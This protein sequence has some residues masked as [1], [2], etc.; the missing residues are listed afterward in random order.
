MNKTHL[1]ALILTALGSFQQV[2]FAGHPYGQ[3]FKSLFEIISL[4]GT[5]SPNGLH[6]DLAVNDAR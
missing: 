5:L 2:A 6:L 4:V 1:S 3:A